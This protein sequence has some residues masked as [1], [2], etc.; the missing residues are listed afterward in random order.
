MPPELSALFS[1]AASA[2]ILALLGTGERLFA[3]D[4]EHI[5]WTARDNGAAAQAPSSIAVLPMHGSL[6]PRG[7]YGMEGFRSR[8]GSAAASPDV[9]AIV[10]DV[11]SPGG[12]VAGTAETAEAVR[13]AAA[14]KP[15]IAI[16]DS[17]AAS[18]AYWI[19]SQASQLWV[20]PSGYV[21]SVGV[22]GMHMDVSQA[23]EKAGVKPTLIT[24]GQYKGEL[25]PFAPL[26][27]AARDNVQSQADQEHENFIRDVSQGRKVS[28]DTVRNTFGQGR[29]V[30][31]QR[32]VDLGMADR[33]GTMS[34]VLNSLRTKSGSVRR[35]TALAFG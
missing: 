19:G 34:D 18:A 11:N 30:S 10:L 31:A 26:T 1:N 21:G 12:T 29:T 5:G 24:S 13:Q 25:S 9:G 33:V 17:L 2:E 7:S 14:Q 15:V 20:T 35:R 4:V 3:L 8:L 28:T 27:D 22:I 6:S 16:A 23:L 32:A